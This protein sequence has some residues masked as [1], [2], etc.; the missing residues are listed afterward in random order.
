[1]LMAIQQLD[2]N[3]FFLFNHL[4]HTAWLDSIARAIYYLTLSSAVY[5]FI[6]LVLL[7]FKKPRWLVAPL[8][9][10]LVLTIVIGDYV[11]K[12]LV[13]RSRPFTS[14]SRV[15]SVMPLPKTSSFPSGQTATAFA[16][17]T[18]AVFT[19][20]R[21]IWILA[22]AWAGLVALSRI[23]MGHH[24]FSDV[25][26]GAVLGSVISW[27]VWAFWQRTPFYKKNPA[28]L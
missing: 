3:I 22:L 15:V 13:N 28:P 1:M 18:M 12:P 21:K 8:V 9:I 4:P 6:A 23:Y 19:K 14:L 26:S 16:A 17:A 25:L 7:G 11:L 27:L 24:Y 20:R 10:S 2:V 5:F